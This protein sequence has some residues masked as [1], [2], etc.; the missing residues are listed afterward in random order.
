M[1]PGGITAGVFHSTP[2]GKFSRQSRYQHEN[3]KLIPLSAAFAANDFSWQN[4]GKSYQ[5][6]WFRA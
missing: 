4:C 1:H 2:L 5:K 6:H 3:S